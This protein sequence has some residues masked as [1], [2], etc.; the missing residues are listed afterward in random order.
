M[1]TVSILEVFVSLQGESTYA[2]LPCF[3]VRLAGCNLRC[4][5]CDTPNV[6]D[7][8]TATPIT[9]LVDQFRRS[10]VAVAE[11][12][13]GEPLLQPEFPALAVALRDTEP[14]RTVLVETNGT[15]DL[16]LVPD[17]VIAVMDIKC[18]GSGQ[19]DAMDWANIA[20]LRR[21]DEVKFV[22]TGRD[23]FEWAAEIVRRYGLVSACHAVHFSPVFGT[24]GDVSF[25][26]SH[27]RCDLRNA[28]GLKGCLLCFKNYACNLCF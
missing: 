2:G 26:E 14:G 8:G 3:F 1:A 24:L 10:R 28:I 20:K 5:Y 6:Y 19:H 12:T 4:R 18:P 15:R 22:V 17:R 13:G 16:A 7:T 21:Y 25:R 9:E 27:N 11:I 23:D